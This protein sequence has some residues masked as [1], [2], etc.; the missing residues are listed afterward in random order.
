M[1]YLVVKIIVIIILG[2]FIKFLKLLNGE[3][4]FI[5]YNDL[6][7]IKEVIFYEQN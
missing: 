4:N 3:F 7:I 2:I 1:I 5:Q 6:I